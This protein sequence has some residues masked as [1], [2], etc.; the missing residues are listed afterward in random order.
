VEHADDAT[1][2]P[3]RPDE[4]GRTYVPPVDPPVVGSEDGDPRIAAGFGRGVDAN[5]SDADH[6]RAA[7]LGDDEMSARIRE[8]LAADSLGS[9]Y[10]E[11]IAIVTVGS[12]A[13]VKGIVE[14][15]DVQDHILGLVA[16]V[17]GVEDVQDR[18]LPE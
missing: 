8:R 6:K 4:E 10:S 11:R 9:E 15:L 13:V 2:D 7:G 12:T 18:L 5:P 14:D 17:P 3:T 16:A 1:S